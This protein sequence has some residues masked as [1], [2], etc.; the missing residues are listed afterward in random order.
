[1]SRH[2]QKLM[3]KYWAG[4]SSLEE[5]KLLKEFFAKEEVPVEWKAFQPLFAYLDTSEKIKA[6]KLYNKISTSHLP[7]HQ[8]PMWRFVAI[9]ATLFFVICIGYILF[10]SHSG[11]ESSKN[12]F[13]EILPQD[14]YEDPEEAYEAA[15]EVLL[16][17]STKMKEGRAM[18]LKEPGKKTEKYEK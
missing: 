16:L 2:I 5:E 11:K 9:A 10:P 6:P 4:E 17:L 7:I 15:K 13:V 1:M 14:T 12:T 3:D 8:K 18:I